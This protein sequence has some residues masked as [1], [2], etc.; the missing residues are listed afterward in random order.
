MSGSVRWVPNSTDERLVGIQ[1]RL[2]RNA[3]SEQFE[4]ARRT[5]NRISS[6]LGIA[7]SVVSM[8][9]LLLLVRVGH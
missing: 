9:D 3:Q 1:V 6:M 7:A 5:A 8:Y 4:R 2:A